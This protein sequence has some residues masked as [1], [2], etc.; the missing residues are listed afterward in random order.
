MKELS[1]KEKIL[2][3]AL[4]LFSEKGYDGVGVDLIAQQVGI[5]GPSL[6]RHYKG[7]EDILNS[8]LDMINERYE[9][10]FGSASN[11]GRLPADVGELI[12]ISKARVAFTMHDEAVRKSRRLL[13]MEQF[14]SER[15]AALTSSHQ[16]DGLQKLYSGIF[17]GM[18]AAGTLKQCDPELL[19]LEFVS[20]ITLLLHIYDREPDREAEVMERMN[21]HFGHFAKE[22][23]I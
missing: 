2:Y 7:K 10:G 13:S 6:Y 16:L 8:L 1:T 23:G 9:A 17:A 15:L 20:P 5:K 21:A 4:E 3:A 11:P 18:M 14:R 19:A 22:Y 12:A